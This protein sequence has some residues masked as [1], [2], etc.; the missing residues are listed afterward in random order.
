M[1]TVPR[2]SE[3]TCC[4]V[5][6]ASFLA[7]PFLGLSLGGW[8]AADSELAQIVSTLTFPASFFLGMLLWMGVGIVRL[9]FG[10]L[11]ALLRGRLPEGAVSSR[12]ETCVPPG[13]GAF[14]VLTPS[15]N[16]IPACV[17][18]LFSEATFMLAVASYL[19]MGIA[20]GGSLWWLAHHGYLAFPEP[21]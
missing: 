7:G 15:L 2:R 14:A 10:T 13:Y 3:W 11:V 9:A 19:L 20:Y 4:L 12:A 17:A 18:A 6:I 1:R 8:L 16:L 21:A 5:L